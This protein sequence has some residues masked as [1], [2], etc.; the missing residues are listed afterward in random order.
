MME[1]AD[2]PRPPRVMGPALGKTWP[3]ESP[4]QVQVLLGAY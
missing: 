2:P 1:V 4:W 3:P